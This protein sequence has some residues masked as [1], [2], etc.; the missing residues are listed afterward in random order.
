MVRSFLE[1][2]DPTTVRRRIVGKRTII[3]LVPWASSDNVDSVS[4]P[5][6]LPEG[7]MPE[8]LEASD[9]DTKKRRVESFD[10]SVDWFQ[11]ERSS[12]AWLT[13]SSGERKYLRLMLV[14]HW[15]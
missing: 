7:G 2:A 1:H 5:D 6:S 10:E 11:R 14:I 9:G 3:P 8:A 13:N 12:T 4:V 15:N